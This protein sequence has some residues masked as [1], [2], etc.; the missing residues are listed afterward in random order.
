MQLRKLIIE[1]FRGLQKIELDFDRT[2]VLIGENNTGKTSIL[3]AIRLCLGRTL[4]KSGSAFDD[5]DYY[6][7]DKTAQPGQ[8]GPLILS[9]KFMEDHPNGWAEEIVEALGDVIVLPE[10]L[11]T[12]ILRVS[13]SFD[14]M[15]RDFITDW[16]FLDASENPLPPY[17]KK[18][19]STLRQICPVFYLTATREADKDFSARSP[20]W[21]PFL[22]NPD[23]P[24]DVRQDL[25]EELN[26]LNARIIE[27]HKSLKEVSENLK[28]TSGIVQLSEEQTV[29][30]EA[31]PGRAFDALSR[32]QVSMTG[33]TGAILPLSRH[34]SGTQ[35][36]S[37]MFLFES[38]L[39]EMLAKTYGQFSEPILTLE[40][41]E[42]HLHPSAI[43][44]LWNILENMRGQKIIATHSGDFLAEVPFRSIRRLCRNEGKIEIR[45]I[46][47]DV[48]N[49]DE[50][51]K[52]EFHVR[53]SRG[54]LFFAR[55]WVLVEGETDHYIITK[56]A[57]LMGDS[58]DLESHGIRIIPH[59]QMGIRALLKVADD[60]GIAWHCLADGDSQGEQDAGSVRAE[61]NNRTESD[62]L[63]ALREEDIELF[64][65]EHGFGKVYEDH[66]SVQKQDQITAAPGDAD[67]WKQVL[68]SMDDTPK[69]A[70]AIEVMNLM[71]E[72]GLEAVPIQL[73]QVVSAAVR[74]ARR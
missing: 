32:A 10:E 46:R 51:R 18:F 62:H 37:V 1:N 35:S 70:L 31:L 7:S 29:T 44:T 69:P 59:R 40:E 72:S 73:K 19:I 71:E 26:I 8:S 34:G 11:R 57:K 53:Y 21:A 50:L 15:T 16:D 30:I 28:K 2:T 49:A 9:F 13:S 17:T 23:I 33:T 63:T 38:F 41:P 36:L 55:C 39:E 56:L 14:E 3:E 66:I 24:T 42:A 58:F 20:F 4:S 54:E 65:C 64:L 22:R 5:Y 12:V 6:L 45:S 67:Y 61:L 60:L 52:L 48:L 74:L 27:A 47:T 68:G 25:E 43:R